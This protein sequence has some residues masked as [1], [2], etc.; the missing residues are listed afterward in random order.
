V[1]KNEDLKITKEL[2]K[3]FERMKKEGKTVT[4]IEKLETTP[5]MVREAFEYQEEKD[6]G[7]ESKNN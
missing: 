5:E 4:D 2:E 7:E 6:K 1:A 3:I